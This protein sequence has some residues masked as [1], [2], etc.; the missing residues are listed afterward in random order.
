MFV[1]P[2]DAPYGQALAR[3]DEVAEH[4]RALHGSD[5]TTVGCR[6][7]MD[8]LMMAFKK[9][10]STHCAHPAQIKYKEREQL[11]QDLSDL[12]DMANKK[13]KAVK[14]ERGKKLDKRETDGHRLR[15]AAVV[16]MKR[17]PETNVEADEASPSKIKESKRSTALKNAAAAIVDLPSILEASAEFKRAELET[18]RDANALLQRKIELEEQR[19]LLDK[20]EREARFAL[21]QQERHS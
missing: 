4:M 19:Y 13:K 1:C 14:E 5:L 16:S 7:R 3:W 12:I 9:D 15:E 6:K 11:L 17:K 21:E 8:D 10:P 18:K 2:H 20:A